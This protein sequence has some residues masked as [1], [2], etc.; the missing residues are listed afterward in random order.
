VAKDK[1]LHAGITQA[2]AI[3]RHKA[4]KKVEFGLP[5]L[6]SRLGGGYVFGRLLRGV[7]DETKMPLQALADYRDIFGAPATP[8]LVVYDRG[9][10]ATATLNQ[11]A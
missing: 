3:V 1:I 6:L 5:Y 7:V 11:L 10:G 2:R 9:G 8:E 4:G